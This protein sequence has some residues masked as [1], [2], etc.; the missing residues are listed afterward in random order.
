M[1]AALEV[2]ARAEIVDCA[3]LRRVFELEPLLMRSELRRTIDDRSGR[4]LG[5]DFEILFQQRR[6]EHQRRADFVEP[7]G[8][9]VG[10]KNLE[11]AL[12]GQRGHLEQIANRVG[13]LHAVHP[14]QHDT[15]AVR[16]RLPRCMSQFGRQPHG[17][18]AR[19]MHLG[20]RLSF[21]RH[22]AGVEP[23]HRLDPMSGRV[24]GREVERQRV[25]P[26]LA[27]LLRGTMAPIAMR[28]EKRLDQRVDLR[29]VEQHLR[30][31]EQQ[32]RR[33]GSGGDVAAR[34]IDRE[35]ES[36]DERASEDGE[37]SH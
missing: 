14:P 4:H 25:E 18:G 10:R 22:L 20:L 1:F 32:G 17:D 5:R 26:E 2:G 36:Y 37:S 7:F 9:A 30:R 16:E 6:I 21:G 27:F 35:H 8:R 15:A 3:V 23:I 34:R 29:R 24:G 19:L 31:V 13:V 11:R 33:V 12:A 28:R